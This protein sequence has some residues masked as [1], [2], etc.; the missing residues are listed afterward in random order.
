MSSAG[1]LYASGL[2]AYRATSFETAVELF[3]DV[4]SPARVVPEFAADRQTPPQAISLAPKSAKLYDAR[5]TAYGKLNKLQE[6]LLD[7][8]Q[9]VKLMPTSHKVRVVPVLRRKT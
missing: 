6:G 8:R 2:A 1:A 5:A 9:V 3:S 4:R 7:A